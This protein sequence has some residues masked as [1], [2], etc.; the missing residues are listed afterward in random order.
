MSDLENSVISPMDQ[1]NSSP[2]SKGQSLSRDDDLDSDSSSERSYGIECWP[3]GKH[4][5]QDEDCLYD[6][7]DDA[8]DSSKGAMK[9]NYNINFD[10]AQDDDEDDSSPFD[11]NDEQP[12]VP[13]GGSH[14]NHDP[15]M[16]SDDDEVTIEPETPFQGQEERV[17]LDGKTV[18]VEPIS[19]ANILPVGSRRRA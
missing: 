1:I 12:Y 6:E 8:S 14:Y 4:S 3:A 10:D 7:S 9:Q 11:S 16:Q 13:P 2:N 5:D 17:Q 15:E 19:L 18:I